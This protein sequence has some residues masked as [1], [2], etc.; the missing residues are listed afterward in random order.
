MTFSSEFEK[1]GLDSSYYPKDWVLQ[2]L[3]PDSRWFGNDSRAAVM[4]RSLRQAVSDIEDAEYDTYGGYNTTGVI[5]HP[6]GLDF[7]GYPVHPK[8][9]SDETVNDYGLD[10]PTGSSWRMVVLMDGRSVGVLP[11]G[12]AGSYFSEHYH[13]QLRMWA[14][15]EYKSLTRE[16]RGTS[17][18]TFERGGTQ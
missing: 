4:V 1:H 7:L 15:G 12:N 9:G 17:T 2:Y 18:L 5:D 13:D 16:I 11:G 14:N 3:G 10:G 6:L 8:D